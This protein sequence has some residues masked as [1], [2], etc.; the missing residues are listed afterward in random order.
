MKLVLD[1]SWLAR[2]PLWTVLTAALL[3]G[4]GA[5]FW[6]GNAPLDATAA[7][8]VQ[9]VGSVVAIIAAIHI[10][11]GTWR[12]EERARLEKEVEAK[13]ALRSA[14]E[15]AASEVAAIRRMFAG[16]DGDSAAF[17]PANGP[18]LIATAIEVLDYYGDR[19]HDDPR[20][21]AALFMAKRDLP[22]LLEEMRRYNGTGYAYSG[23]SIA[24]RDAEVTIEYALASIERAL[25]SG[26][27]SGGAV[28]RR[29]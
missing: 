10:D 8:W 7:A 12:R 5:G 14:V 13:H 9:G 16:A 4:F 3:A 19:E 29:S 25:S 1:L 20:L 24:L 11:R 17:E 2:A 21:V 23:M 27:P 18:R 28:G 22:A 15:Y 6:A 26:D